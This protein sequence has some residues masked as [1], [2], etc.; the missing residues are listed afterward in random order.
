MITSLF[1]CLLGIISGG[2]VGIIPGSAAFVAVAIFYSILEGL[3]AFNILLFYI[4][5]LITT[6]YT[7]SICA[8]LYGIPG[9]ATAIATARYGHKFFRK[10]FGHLAVSSNAISSSIGSMFAIGLFIVFYDNIYSIFKFYNSTFQVVIISIAIFL[11]TVSVKQH[12]LKTILLFILGG[13]LAKIGF[14]N[15]TFKSWGTFGN[16]YLSLGIPFNAVMIGLFIIPEFLKFVDLQISEP[17]KITKFGMGKN[18]LGATLLGSFIGFWS[19]LIPGITNILGSYASAAIVKRYF[20]M[21]YLKC[22]AAA[23]AAN[24]SG[25]LSSLLPLIIL[26]I[27][28]VGSEVLVFYLVS[29]TGFVFGLETIDTF[30]NIL[31]FIPI[32]IGICLVISWAGFNLLG[33]ISYLIKEYKNYITCVIIVIISIIATSM[34]PIKEWMIMC[35]IGLTLVGYFIRKWD[36]IPIVYG[37]FLTDLFWD[38]LIR[39]MI[40]HF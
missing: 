18:T 14:D 17:R 30:K 34:Y 8:I 5:V 15:L 13:V 1:W 36:T 37:Y 19:G 27:P 22:I 29:S 11:I 39:T 2:I 31:Y 38:N 12:I 24:N 4:A 28:I 20:K 35:I 40:I 3:S 7:N 25:A 16:P 9:D 26:G 10:G 32:I 6:N 21:P 33:K 23:E